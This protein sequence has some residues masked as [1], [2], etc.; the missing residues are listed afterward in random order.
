MILWLH[1]INLFEIISLNFQNVNESIIKS[2]WSNL[3]NLE[4]IVNIIY[5]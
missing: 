2:M 5:N 4:I 1:L 3:T